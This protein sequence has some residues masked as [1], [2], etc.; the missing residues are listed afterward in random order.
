VSADRKNTDRIDLLRRRAEQ[1]LADRLARG[2]NAPDL[3]PEELPH[4]LHTLQTYQIE[5]EMQNDELRTAQGELERLTEKFRDLFEFAPVGY[6]SVGRDGRI[7]EANLTATAL[8]NTDRQCLLDNKLT[9]FIAPA[10]QDGFYLL[11]RRVEASGEKEKG[12]FVMMRGD[13]SPFHAELDLFASAALG[14]DA[15]DLLVVI[16]DISFRVQSEMELQDLNRELDQKVASRTKELILANR[17]LE[18][19]ATVRARVE[20]QLQTS[21]ETYR[22]LVE[23]VDSIILKITAEGRIVFLNTFGQRFLGYRAGDLLNRDVKET[24]IPRTDFT[25]DEG[26]ESGDRRNPSPAHGYTSESRYKGMDGDYAWVS[27]TARP[28]FDSRGNTRE[29]FCVGH[30]ITRR[31]QLEAR[32]FRVSEEEQRRIGDDLHDSVGQQLAGLLFSVGSLQKRLDAR[33]LSEAAEAAK[34]IEQLQATATEV[35]SL[36]RGL[37]PV[38]REDDGLATALEA[39]ARDVK[40]KVRIGCRCSWKAPVP[41]RDGEVATHLYRIAQEAIANAIKHAGAGS[42]TIGLEQLK[43]KIVMTITDDGGE[44]PE[45]RPGRGG[46]GLQIMANRAGLIG[47]HLRIVRNDAGG[48]SVI[49]IAPADR[50]E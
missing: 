14:A 21:K 22:E 23:N 49:C 9:D 44:P 4:L 40:D 10:S 46:R 18:A 11:R 25:A 28:V 5:L 38:P 33:G 34:I 50:A 15:D 27:W 35:R 36:A 45:A 42:I 29:F 20:E 2:I 26:Q 24:I 41:V 30:D 39:L 7:R 31:K 3:T 17:R 13:G 32:L 6:L 47:G 16:S 19:E 8:L 12:E 43:S 48:M 37:H 1:S